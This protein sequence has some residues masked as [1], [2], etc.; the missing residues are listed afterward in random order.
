MPAAVNIFRR[1]SVSGAVGSARGGAHIQ[2]M[3]GKYVTWTPGVAAEVIALTRRGLTLGEI[4]RMEGMPSLGAF[5]RWRRARPDLEAAYLEAC[6]ASP[7]WRGPLWSGLPGEVTAP[8]KAA[9]P[10][11]GRRARPS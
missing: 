5:I 10:R 6:A 1:G 2:G 8:R 9:K 11:P 3:R 4:C 7:R